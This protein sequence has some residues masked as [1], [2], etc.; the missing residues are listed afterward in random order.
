MED[1]KKEGQ[2]QNKENCETKKKKEMPTWARIIVK[3]LIVLVVTIFTVAVYYVGYVV[4]SYSRIK[5]NQ[6]LEIEQLSSVDCASLNKEYTIVTQNIGFGAYT[7]DFTFF[8]DGGTE[9]WAKSKE[10]INDCINEGMNKIKSFN[11]DFVLIQEVDFDSTRTYHIDERNIIKKYFENFS[12]DFAVNY[13]S[14]FLMY[15]LLQPHGASKSGIY[16][17]S[18]TKIES[19]IRRSLPIS[20]SFSKFL[21]LDRCYSKSKIK[22]END[23]YLVIYNAHLSAYGSD[24][25]IREG[26][27]RMLFS[28]MQEEYKLG[29]YCV[30]GGDFNHDFTGDSVSKLNGSSEV[31][32]LG[33]AQPFPIEILNEYQEIQRCI[34]YNDDLTLPTCRNCD[35]P[36]V[37]GNFTIIVDG[38]LASEN[39]EIT[40]LE[41]IQTGFAYSDHN[42]VVMKF[43]LK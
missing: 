25:S 15:P 13:H 37:E 2:E 10:S 30:C 35:I 22:L 9:S 23:K 5:D 1:I 7:P 6:D 28:D 18:F 12:N 41:N 34:N 39:V 43:I 19:A 20:K 36:Y 3:T 21:D 27:M 38:F 14:A 24:A 42:P 31:D 29:N 16:T 11:P 32:S 4:F 26:Q 17:F 33:W 40:F 8:M